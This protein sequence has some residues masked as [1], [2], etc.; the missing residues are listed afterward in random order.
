MGKSHEACQNYTPACANPNPFQ[1]NHT[2]ECHNYII[3]LIHVKIPLECV[4]MKLV[5]VGFTLVRVEITVY[6]YKS[7]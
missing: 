1:I 4:E 6:V 5:S 3:T 7:H 2:R